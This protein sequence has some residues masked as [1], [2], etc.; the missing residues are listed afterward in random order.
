MTK[1][2]QRFGESSSEHNNEEGIG[3]TL[4]GCPLSSKWAD[5]QPQC[6]NWVQRRR[7]SASHPE[8]VKKHANCG[9]RK[10]YREDGCPMIN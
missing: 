5:I 8:Y 1:C 2:T 3:L 7:V 10:V 4:E 9:R 6:H